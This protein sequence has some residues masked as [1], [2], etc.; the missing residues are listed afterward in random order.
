MQPSAVEDYIFLKNKIEV[1]ELLF[2]AIGCEYFVE[3]FC[4]F[5]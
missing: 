2:Y 5:K 1:Y 3:Y 4:I